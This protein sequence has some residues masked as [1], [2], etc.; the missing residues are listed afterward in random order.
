M[1]EILNKKTIQDLANTIDEEYDITSRLKRYETMNPELMSFALDHGLGS[2]EN[3]TPAL[4]VADFIVT[5]SEVPQGGT[6]DET[7]E[8]FI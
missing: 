8:Y 6:D 7:C 1:K 4:F 3:S 5:S 2:A